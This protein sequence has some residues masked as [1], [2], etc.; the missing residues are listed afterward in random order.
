MAAVGGKEVAAR[1]Q[2]WPIE[3]F[4]AREMGSLKPPKFGGA[5]PRVCFL[6][7]SKGSEELRFVSPFPP[8]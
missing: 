4:R 5:R 3:R 1:D 2:P 7:R 6:F 8:C